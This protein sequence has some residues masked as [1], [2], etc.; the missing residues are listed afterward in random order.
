MAFRLPTQDPWFYTTYEGA[1]LRELIE[2]ANMTM[3]E[4]LAWIEEITEL[5]ERMRRSSAA[6][7]EAPVPRATASES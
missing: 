3:I 7:P 1:R 5:A 2:S 4:K 6:F